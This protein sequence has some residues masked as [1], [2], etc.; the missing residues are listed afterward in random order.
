MI[1]V[2]TFSTSS[3]Q[4]VGKNNFTFSHFKYPKFKVNHIY[5]KTFWK[6]GLQKISAQKSGEKEASKNY[7]NLPK[8]YLWKEKF[9]KKFKEMNLV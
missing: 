4:L 5:M 8:A 3:N 1:L 9:N 7:H 2:N 6:G